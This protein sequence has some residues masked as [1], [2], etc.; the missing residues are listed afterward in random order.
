MYFKNIVTF[1]GLAERLN[2]KCTKTSETRFRVKT[3]IRVGRGRKLV[4]LERTGLRRGCQSKTWAA[5]RN[6]PCSDFPLGL[7]YIPWQKF[8]SRLSVG[9]RRTILPPPGRIALTGETCLR[10]INWPW[11]SPRKSWQK[12]QQG[13][14]PPSL[15]AA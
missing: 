4:P 7:Q 2:E 9:Y 3:R 13:F 15:A 8:P 14:L 6:L 1:Q 10:S 12:L 5:M 11:S